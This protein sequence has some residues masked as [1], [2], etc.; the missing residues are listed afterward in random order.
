MSIHVTGPVALAL[1]GLVFSS[2]HFD[3]GLTHCGCHDFVVSS[4]FLRSHAGVF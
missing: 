1:V 4:G 2:I 3:I